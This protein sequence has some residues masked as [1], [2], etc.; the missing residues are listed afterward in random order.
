MYVSSNSKTSKLQQRDV[1]SDYKFLLSI[2]NTF[3]VDTEE[4]YPKCYNL[5][6]EKGLQILYH[7]SISFYA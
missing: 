4:Y 6:D 1:I 7:D 2:L 3:T 5:Y